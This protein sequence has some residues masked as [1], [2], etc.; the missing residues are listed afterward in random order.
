MD[1]QKTGKW[2]TSYCKVNSAAIS[3]LI[4]NESSFWG[5]SAG[6]AFLHGFVRSYGENYGGGLLA[7][8]GSAFMDPFW[9][10]TQQFRERFRV[11]VKATTED[12]THALQTTAYGFYKYT[13]GLETRGDLEAPGGHCSAWRVF[14]GDSRRVV[15]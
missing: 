5:G 12:F 14:V 6:S 13:L 9:N 10:P 8:C 15:A 11:L 4:S 2:S 1:R 3:R 7:W